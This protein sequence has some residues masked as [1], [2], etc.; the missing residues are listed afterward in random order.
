MI[1][2]GA[3]AWY[4]FRAAFGR[5]RGGYLSVVLLIGLL[6]GLAMGAVAAARRTQSSFPTFLASTNP[7]DM[8]IFTGPLPVSA[9]EHLPG[10]KRVE[11]AD[12]LN[13]APLGSNG[14]PIESGAD[15]GVYAIGSS[16]GLY[17]NQDRFT[18][19]DGRMANPSEIDQAVVTEQAAQDLGLRVGETVRVGVYTNAQTGLPG[20][21][22]AAVRPHARLNLQVVGIVVSNSAVVEDDAER[23]ISALALLT[24]AL[25]S[26]FASCCSPD[27]TEFGV[28]LKGGG[29]DISTV[30]T[31]IERLLPAG[32]GFYVS[33]TS[34][35]EAEAQ[36][37]IQPESIA[38]GVFGG[39]AAL[40]T[41]LIAGQV[42]G[43]QLRLG[44]RELRTLRA[45]GADPAMTSSDGL[46]GVVGA[47]FLGSLLA[48]A[49]AV[50]LSPIG[51]IGPVRPVYP[52]PGF[53]FD[54]TVLG[55]GV[56]G[57]ILILSATAGLATYRQAP[58]RAS[59]LHERTQRASYLHRI[60]VSW[61]LPV[62]ALTGARFA[63]ETDRRRDAASLRSAILGALI[64]VIVMTAT[65]TFA[66][67]LNTLV[68]HPAL[69]GWN[70]NYELDTSEGGG[71][72]PTKEAAQLLDH[73]HDV[74][75]WTGVYFDSLRVDGDTIPII[76]GTP[77]ASVGPPIL[78]GHR[79]QANDQIVLGATS[80]AELHKQVGDTVEVSYGTIAK[81]TPLRIVGTATMPA[82]GPGLGLHLSMGTG[83][84]VSDLL[85]PA[86]VRAPMSGPAG[87]NAI[88]VRLRAGANPTAALQ[89]LQRID[90]SLDSDPNAAPMS[91]LSA[92]RPADIVNYRSMGSIPAFLG[93]ALAAGAI[94]ALGL[95]LVASVRYRRR[96]LAMLK[97]LGLTRRQLAAVVAWQSS[98]AVLIGT[99]VGIPSGIALGRFFWDTFAHEINAVPAPAVSATAIVLVGVGALLLANIVAAVPGRIAARTPTAPFLRAE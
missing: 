92:Q 20:F 98:I 57:L 93:V 66:T 6:G 7:S 32:S 29:D 34:V 64:A 5:R 75:A 14:A 70:W 16:D 83:A 44:A 47:V 30:E 73:D 1:Q 56:L 11:S 86:V 33:T 84:L 25:T 8:S 42:I 3:V 59:E 21:G 26:R 65:L 23:S 41:L 82:V 89:S 95:T 60:L 58:H 17:F 28:Q 51:P 39:V 79:L 40:A 91:L 37:A 63:L 99:V 87:P 22:T 9:L 36:R 24:P 15:S 78:S 69:Y 55:F 50:V 10:V 12:L 81:R 71:F 96:D 4:R 77:D 46:V 67:S 48:A 45:L 72:I 61:G 54:W 35:V 13:I 19:I 18:V 27:E 74:A 97:T 2:V 49:V 38:L 43:R 80:L 88:F 90:A 52:T 31:A 94:V 76:G 53:A 68:S 62:S 85:I